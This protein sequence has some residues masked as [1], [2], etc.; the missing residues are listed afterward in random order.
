VS[1]LSLLCLCVLFCLV[2][3]FFAVNDDENSPSKE[4]FP[5]RDSVVICLRIE[6]DI[7]YVSNINDKIHYSH[8]KMSFPL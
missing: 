2:V 6:G 8:F 1:V 4:W 7:I 3:F 5:L